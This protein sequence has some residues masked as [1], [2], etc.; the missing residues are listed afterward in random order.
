MVAIFKENDIS[1]IMSKMIDTNIEYSMCH[2]PPYLIVEAEFTECI[3]S[4]AQ[5]VHESIDLND[6][7]QEMNQLLALSNSQYSPHA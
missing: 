3:L 7:V 1:L 2:I 6:Y 5:S 4:I